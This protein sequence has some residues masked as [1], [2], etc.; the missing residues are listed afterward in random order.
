MAELN[1]NVRKTKRELNN[2]QR[3]YGKGGVD[4]A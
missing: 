2:M 1:E 4:H 3:Y